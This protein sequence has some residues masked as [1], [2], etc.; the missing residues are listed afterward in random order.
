MII[1]RDDVTQTVTISIVDPDTT[2]ATIEATVRAQQPAR[3]WSVVV[4]TPTGL[5]IAWRVAR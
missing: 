2:L 5:P 3:S 1:V 4:M